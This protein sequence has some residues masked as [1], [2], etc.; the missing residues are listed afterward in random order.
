[1]VVIQKIQ[2]RKDTSFNACTM[3]RNIPYD[4]FINMAVDLLDW[5]IRI[6]GREIRDDRS[7]GFSDNGFSVDGFPV[8]GKPDD[9]E[10]DNGCGCS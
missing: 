1:M 8:V 9:G 7:V 3:G 4:L 10:A 5:L 2:K 6:F